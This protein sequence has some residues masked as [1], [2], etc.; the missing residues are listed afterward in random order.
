MR[1]TPDVRAVGPDPAYQM[2]DLFAGPGGLDVAAHWLGISA[3]GVEWDR[4][5]L[6]TRKAARI[7]T[8]PGDVR[9]LGPSRFEGASILAGGPPCQT[10]TV[11]GTGSGREAL[12]EVLTFVKR[13]GAREDI[14]DDL[15]TLTDERTGLVLEP[16]RWAIEAQE[17]EKAYDV[18]VLE[19]VPAVLPVWEAM[20]QVL[21]DMEYKTISGV[22]ATEQ[23]GVPQSRRRAILLA[24]KEI[25]PELP[26]TTHARHY[27]GQHSKD[28]LDQQRWV[29]MGQALAAMPG[30]Q[31]PKTFRVVSN[32][33]SGG[34]PK[35]RGERASCQPSATI[36]GKV[37]R[38]R[39]LDA[40]G[41]HLPRFSNQEAGVLQTFPHDFP[42][43][44][45]D[46]GQQ[47]GNAI[48][49]R[50]GVYVL[51]AALGIPVDAARLDAVVK[52]PWTESHG[53]LM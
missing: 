6:A 14:S 17:A 29:S 28:T 19:Q 37:R 26:G 25:Q 4:G 32:Y 49:P 16:L 20:E 10:Y 23:Y 5:A 43:S 7:A 41:N 1:S 30:T 53:R 39:I 42:W 51:S 48:P 11:A 33:G 31:R 34:N 24:N 50:L 45:V 12:A 35:R 3:I 8:E 18:V 21:Q 9:E 27:R 36:T 40:D 44:G 46:I 38:N 13:L 2:V 22:L 52:L 47:I 15:N